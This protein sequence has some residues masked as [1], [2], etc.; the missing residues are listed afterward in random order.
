M[1][2]FG[3]DAELKREGRRLGMAALNQARALSAAGV[4]EGVVITAL[5]ECNERWGLRGVVMMMQTW[6]NAVVIDMQMHGL[7]FA[8]DRVPFAIEDPDTGEVVNPDT[9]PGWAWAARMIVAARSGDN[10]NVKALLGQFAALDEAEMP[11]YVM[12]LL[13][14]AVIH[15]ESTQ[16]RE[17]EAGE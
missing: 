17:W 13:G 7:M 12:C 9:Q 6:V 10:A 14:A 5:A 1:S 15:M 11:D 16:R 2:L 4:T 8:P 3:P